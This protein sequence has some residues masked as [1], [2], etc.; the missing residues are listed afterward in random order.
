MHAPW[1]SRANRPGNPPNKVTSLARP[2]RK[3]TN[4]Q[5]QL[6]TSSHTTTLTTR[7]LI[8]SLNAD[9]DAGPTSQE[10][11]PD[12]PARQ[13]RTAFMGASLP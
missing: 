6:V 7:G 8:Y 12:A 9:T 1:P 5:Q 11:A 13:E 10:A 4:R 3:S 2:Q